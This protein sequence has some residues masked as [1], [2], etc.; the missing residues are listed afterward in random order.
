[1]ESM[2]TLE[3][4]TEG[5]EIES[6]DGTAASTAEGAAVPSADGGV[7][8]ADG[9]EKSLEETIAEATAVP[10]EENSTISTQPSAEIPI[11][12]SADA[13]IAYPS[14]SNVTQTNADLSTSADGV[15]TTAEAAYTSVEA[16]FTS[17]VGTFATQDLNNTTDNSG[18]LTSAEA[19]FTNADGTV[20]TAEGLAY[21]EGELA[22]PTSSDGGIYTTSDGRVVSVP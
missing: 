16:A 21:S 18:A 1:M 15:Y 4:V 12:M 5:K 7:S 2:P 6:A 22:I 13:D 9:G 17:A 10:S 11:I 14:A 3:G 8:S 19:L 20:A